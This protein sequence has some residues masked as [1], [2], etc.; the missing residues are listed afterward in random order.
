[1]GA[2]TLPEVWSLQ[3]FELDSQSRRENHGT[4]SVPAPLCGPECG[5]P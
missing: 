1:V 3:E 2:L 4:S 5:L